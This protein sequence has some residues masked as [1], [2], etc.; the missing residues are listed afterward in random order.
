MDVSKNPFEHVS[1]DHAAIWQMLVYRDIEAFAKSDW[2]LIADDFLQDKFYGINARF[3]TDPHEWQLDF[4]ILKDYRDSW[5]AQ[6][7]LS[8]NKQ[9]IEPLI[10][11]IHKATTIEKMQIKSNKAAVWKKFNGE[12]KLVDGTSEILKWQTIYFCEYHNTS[13][14]IIG[15]IGYLPL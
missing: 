7:Q 14:K 12:I 3:S 15:F 8:R 4:P 5:L 11:G 1:K 6:S 2:M 10:I 9:Y 13:W